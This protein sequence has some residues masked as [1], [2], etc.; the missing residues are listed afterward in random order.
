MVRLIQ[1]IW[2]SFLLLVPVLQLNAQSTAKPYAAMLER[3]GNSLP[4]KLTWQKDTLVNTYALYRRLPGSPGWG[5]AIAT[6]NANDTFYTDAN[7]TNGV[8]EYYLQKNLKNNRSGHGY[9]MVSTAPQLFQYS[10][11]LLLLIDGNYQLPLQMEI[12]YLIGDLV[13][14]GWWVDTAVIQRSETPKQ[15]KQKVLN[16]YAKYAN[17]AVKPEALYLLGRIPVP[18]SGE[19][20]PDGHRPDHRGAWPADVYYGVINEDAWTDAFVNIDSAAQPRNHN[21][22]ND[23]KFDLSLIYPDTNALQ[24]GRVDLSNMPLFGINDTL[25]VRNYLEKAH[26][27]KT[28]AFVPERRALVDDHFG[29]MGGEAFAASGFRSFATMFGKSNVAEADYLPSI[30]Q[31]SYLFTY[32][33]GAGTYTSAFGVANSGNLVSD[34][35]NTVFTGLFGSYFGDWDNANNFLRAPL[36]SKPMALAS[37]WSGRP[38]WNLHHMSMGYTIGYAARL[39]QNNVDGRLLNPPALLGYHS[40]NFPTFIHIALMGDPTLR[41]FYHPK[42][43]F[44]TAVPNSDTTTYTISVSKPQGVLEYQIYVSNSYFNPGKWVKTTTD[45]VFVLN[46]IN[47]GENYVSIRAKY[48]ETAASGSFYQLSPGVQVMLQGGNNAVGLDEASK[49]WQAVLY[50]N[51]SQGKFMVTGDF[52]EVKITVFDATGRIITSN[53]K[54]L[55]GNE[56]TIDTTPGLYFVKMEEGEKVMVKRVLIQP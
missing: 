8:Y 30:K 26:A 36:C 3:E 53:D 42:P 18:Y 15:V 47:K 7:A 34:S 6:L 17:D 50:P 32:G 27:F 48:L 13:A 49:E 31:G 44:F 35:I 28:R 10:G 52:K 43:D 46:H 55:N 12:L 2:I 33:C 23:G 4:V 20:F 16:W 9:I 41:L 38:H 1:I 25:L 45:S 11:R 22:P 40:S 19:I 56:I 24:I 21:F 14:D 39:A 54:V 5:T 29:A 51:P 37:F